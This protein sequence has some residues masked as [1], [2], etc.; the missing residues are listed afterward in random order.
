MGLPPGHEP[1]GHLQLWPDPRDL[2]DWGQGLLH[3]GHQLRGEEL[4][5]AHHG[6]DQRGEE[7]VIG[8]RKV[9]VSGS[10]IQAVKTQLSLSSLSAL[11][12]FSFSS[13]SALFI[14]PTDRA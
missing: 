6:H 5:A 3:P 12:Q 13:L 14:C 2:P 8:A 11:F 1:G 9:S 7:E 4:R 10:D